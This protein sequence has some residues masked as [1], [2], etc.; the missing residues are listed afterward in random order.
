MKDPIHLSRWLALSGVTLVVVGFAML[1]AVPREAVAQGAGSFVGATHSSPITL[2]ADD[3]LMAV[4][5]P[6]VNTVTFFDVG[7]D[8]NVS[9][10]EIAVGKEPNGV[11]LSP[12]GKFAYVA[13][14]VDGTVSVLQV[15]V[16]KQPVA[17][18]R[19]S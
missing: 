5:N 4:V 6:D 9:L 15:D 10:G 19:S 17:S 11:V 1:F 16:S 14:T 2:N 3:T 18:P 13:N 12:D 8:K 7:G